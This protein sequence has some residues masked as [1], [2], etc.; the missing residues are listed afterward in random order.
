MNE[1]ET[2]KEKYVSSER[3]QKNYWWFNIK[4]RKFLIT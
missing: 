2:I 3:R 4:G 1:E